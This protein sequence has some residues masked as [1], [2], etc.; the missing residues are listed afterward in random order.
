M[1][2]IVVISDTLRRDY[3][4]C[5]GNTW[6]RTPNIDAL[7]AKATVCDKAYIG[8]FPTMPMR[9]DIVTGKVCF[10]TY[11]WAPLPPGSTTVQGILQKEGFIA[12]MVTDHTQMLAP[13]MNYHQGFDG[14]EWIRGQASDKWRTDDVEIK[15]PCAPEKLRNPEGWFERY[16]RNISTRRDERDWFSPQTMQAAC[17]WLESNYTHENF[18]L[19]VDTFDVH[20]PWTPLPYYVDMYDPGYKGEVVI[21]PR[22]DRAGYLSEA[23]LHHVRALYAGTITMMDKGF[24]RLLDKIET[25]GIWDETAILFLSDH[26]WYHGEHGY[27]G[28]HTVLD[29][30]KGWPFYEEVAHIPLIVKLPGQREGTRTPVLTQPV[31][32]MP[33]LLDLAGASV[34]SDLHGGSILPALKGE[35]AGPRST[36]VSSGKLP[37]DPGVLAY[38]TITDG[39][40]TLMHPGAN[41]SPELYHLPSDP[42][43]TQN[44]MHEHRTIATDLHHAYLDLLNQIDTPPE[45][46]ALRQQ[47]GAD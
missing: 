24:G 17:T 38:S 46:L 33:T 9:S 5:Y 3:L 7:A 47:L 16:M 45:R 27:I 36:A 6:V 10:H 12:M 30:T 20:E 29:R 37:D 43:Q 11:G 22:Y 25:L 41:A 21:Y 14:V 8:S 39:E 31:D 44:V 2:I 23:E 34:P 42:A 4:G 26:G 32:L 1:K 35:G 40:W 18:L 13:G 28:K 19:W 15:W